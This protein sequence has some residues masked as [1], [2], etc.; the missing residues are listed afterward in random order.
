[1][2]TYRKLVILLKKEWLIVSESESSLL[3]GLRSGDPA[4]FERLV[5]SNS[6]RLLA[7]ASRILGSER[8]AQD[9]VQEALIS[10][11]KSIDTFEG[12]SSLYTWLHRI[13]VNACLA[14]LRTARSKSE[15]SIA[16]ADRPV[17]LAFEGLPSAWSHSG[18][19][20]EQR[21]AMR[22]AIQ[23]ALNLIPEDLRIVLLL[24]DVE[25]LSSHEVSERLGIADTAVR[26]RLHR[27]RTAMAEVLRPELCGGPELTCGGQVHLLLDYID[28]KLPS[29][30]QPP[31]HA[32]IEGCL[33]CTALL[34][35]YRKTIGIPRAIAGLTSPDDVSHGWISQT[36][37]RG[38]HG[39]KP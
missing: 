30:L 26:Q 2:E 17:S 24:R 20:L 29:A 11:W 1:M 3:I 37:T 7:T 33:A 39:V 38:F 8:D 23:K 18:P 10:A 21:L 6:A 15:V 36:V 14:R 34:N 16:D 4:S 22:R 9:V 5:R 12:T 28:N 13:A 27:A 31:V 35:T 19:S 25:E 32:H